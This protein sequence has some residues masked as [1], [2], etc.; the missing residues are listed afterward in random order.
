MPSGKVSA[1]HD[2]QTRNVEKSA[3]HPAARLKFSRADSESVV[4]SRFGSSASLLITFGFATV[5]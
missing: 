4:A 5:R 1:G 2:F 3:I